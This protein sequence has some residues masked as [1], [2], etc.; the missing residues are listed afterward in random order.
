M[1]TPITKKTKLSQG[2]FLYNFNQ[3]INRIVH[4]EIVRIAGKSVLMKTMALTGIPIQKN[5]RQEIEFRIAALIKHE[6]YLLED[7][8]KDRDYWPRTIDE[9]IDKLI[10][11]YSGEDLKMIKTMDWI[12][13]NNKYNSYGSIAQWIRNYFGLYRGN[14]DLLLDCD[15]KEANADNVSSIIVYKLWE[16]IKDF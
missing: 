6:F 10:L 16:K 8:F 9:A 15:T 1:F 13:F 5:E 14:Y 4:Y 2:D 11:K 3:I 12:E 7:E